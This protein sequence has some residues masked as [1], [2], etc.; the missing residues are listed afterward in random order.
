MEEMPG[1][2]LQN[3]EAR[4]FNLLFCISHDLNRQG[5]MRSAT[6][7]PASRGGREARF[8]VKLV[9]PGLSPLA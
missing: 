2:G 4:L 9:P 7:S 8:R 3:A 1:P 5:E 6:G